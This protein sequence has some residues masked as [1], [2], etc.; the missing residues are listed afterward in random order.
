[1]WRPQKA[2]PTPD[3]LRQLDEYL[4]RL[5]LDRGTLVVF[6]RRPEAAPLPDGVGF[7]SDRTPSGRPVTVLRA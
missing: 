6:D 7:E 2:D 4:K 5:D 3:G 1:M